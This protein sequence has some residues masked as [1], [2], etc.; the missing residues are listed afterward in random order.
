MPP[1][2]AGLPAPLR[3]DNAPTA[4]EAHLAHKVVLGAQVPAR[5]A[6]A[7]GTQATVLL[8]DLA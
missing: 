5:V 4:I 7:G 6:L 3:V 1:V 2:P 8:W